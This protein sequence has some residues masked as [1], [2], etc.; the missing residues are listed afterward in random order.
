M[1]FVGGLGCVFLSGSEVLLVQVAL[2]API[3]DKPGKF[4]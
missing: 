3:A 1:L 2:L 4:S